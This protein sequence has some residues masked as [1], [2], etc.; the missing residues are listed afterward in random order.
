MSSEHPQPKAG[1]GNVNYPNSSVVT[2]TSVSRQ[3]ADSPVTVIYIRY[4]TTTEIYDWE[5][6]WSE[7]GKQALL[8]R[9]GSPLVGGSG[10]GSRWSLWNYGSLGTSSMIWVSGSLYSG[11]CRLTQSGTSARGRCSRVLCLCQESM[12]FHPC[13]TESDV[14]LAS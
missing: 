7:I 14:L 9:C 6:V 5:R 4:V 11:R 1:S 2:F 13:M 10:K 8:P 3:L 12:C